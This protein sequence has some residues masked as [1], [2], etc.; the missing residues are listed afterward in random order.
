MDFLER[1][2][3]YTHVDGMSVLGNTK[4]AVASKRP[5]NKLVGILVRERWFDAHF[6]WT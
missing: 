2:A 6:L 3:H 5:T 4:A 1:A